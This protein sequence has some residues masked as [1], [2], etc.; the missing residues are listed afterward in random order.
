M[1][2]GESS[3]EGASQYRVTNVYAGVGLGRRRPNLGLLVL[4]A[5]RPEA[6]ANSF[7]L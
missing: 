7:F 6:E 3:S 5:S 1:C 4:D 2:I